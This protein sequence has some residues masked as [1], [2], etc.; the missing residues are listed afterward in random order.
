MKLEK[1]KKGRRRKKEPLAAA[2]YMVVYKSE[3]EIEIMIAYG[4]KF[5]FSE[6]GRARSSDDFREG[7]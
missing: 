4:P 1:K 5:T 7:S 6:G 3:D 2:F